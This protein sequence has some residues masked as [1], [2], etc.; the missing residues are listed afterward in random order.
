MMAVLVVVTTGKE[1]FVRANAI[2]QM[3]LMIRKS[4]GLPVEFLAIGPGVE[5]FRS[6]QRNSP[7]FGQLLDQL[8]EAG[9]QLAACEVSLQSIG[10]TR[11]QMFDAEI[12]RGGVEVAQRIQDGYTVLTF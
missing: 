3:T 12:V 2:L 5:I 7:Q 8:R 6:N 10:L 1:Q 4:S 11:D 9:V